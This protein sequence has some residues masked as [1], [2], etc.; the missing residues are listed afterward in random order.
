MKKA[1]DVL[2]EAVKVQEERAKIYNSPGGERNMDALVAAF[3]AITKHKLTEAE[4]FLFLQLL[5]N[6]RLFCAPG[7]HED[8]AVDNVSYAALV[9]E[10][11]SKERKEVKAPEPW[12][13]FWIP[14]SGLG[15]PVW[16]TDRVDIKFR[17]GLVSRN[18]D[19]TKFRWSHADWPTDI[20]KYR[21]SRDK[22]SETEW[23]E[24]D[25]KSMPFSGTTIVD[26]Q[27]RNGVVLKNRRARNFVWPW[28]PEKPDSGLDII[29]YAIC[30]QQSDELCEQEP[31]EIEVTTI[32][33]PVKQT[34]PV[35]NDWI[36]VRTVGIPV[37]LDPTEI[38]DVKMNNGEIIFNRMAGTFNP[39]A[40]DKYRSYHI[41][42][43]RICS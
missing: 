24:H 17:N 10:A 19:P 30:K 18:A 31:N 23:I 8:S 13:D 27:L 11:K 39:D 21:Y 28:N 43:Y 14:H 25:G 32:D 35:E 38:I 33:S 4:G 40:W 34:I 2:T 41:D 22:M 1:I 26:L 20:V 16:P 6:I 36:P 37:S 5:K 9:A 29:R 15:I 3:A 42:C 7:F 12:L